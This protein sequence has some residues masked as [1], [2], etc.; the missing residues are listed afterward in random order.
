[1]IGVIVDK[2]ADCSRLV[3]ILQVQCIP[4][5]IVVHELLPFE[6]GGLQ[7]RECPGFGR[8]LAPNTVVDV[9]PVYIS[10]LLTKLGEAKVD[11]QLKVEDHAE[12]STITSNSLDQLTLVV[13][14]GHFS[15]TESIVLL[16]DSADFLEELMTSGTTGVVL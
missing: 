7:L 13:N 12:L 16:E 11:L 8:E 5:L 2:A 1:M 15:N 14:T 9:H 3:M 6:G 4:A 10:S